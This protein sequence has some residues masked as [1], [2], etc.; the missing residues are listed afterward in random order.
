MEIYSGYPVFPQTVGPLTSNG[1]DDLRDLTLAAGE[2]T[3]TATFTLPNTFNTG[4]AWTTLWLPDVAANLQLNSSFSVRLDGT[5][6]N[7]YVGTNV[8]TLN[9]IQVQ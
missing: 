1:S 9:N 7:W 8:L 2:K 6:V 4:T 3:Y 5:N